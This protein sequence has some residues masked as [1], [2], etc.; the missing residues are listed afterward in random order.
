MK[1]TGECRED[2]EIFVL[3]YFRQERKDYDK[4]T[5]N[6]V[7]G[8]FSRMT[9]IFQNALIIEFF[10]SV[11]IYV[12]IECYYDALL[13]YNRGFEAIVFDEQ[14]NTKY[15]CNPSDCFETRLE[16]ISKAIEKVN[17]IYNTPIAY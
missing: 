2:F 11:G 10:D 17:E 8:K 7:L 1:L 3:K 15:D 14:E 6:T 5:D 12:S 13:G 9:D 4:F 16:A